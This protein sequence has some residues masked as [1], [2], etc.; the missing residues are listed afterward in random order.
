MYWI[1]NILFLE[2]TKNQ[3]SSLLSF[4]KIFVK[5]HIEKSPEEIL[6]LFI[7]DET[8]YNNQ[9][10]P[11]FEWIIEEF[12]KDKF[13]SELK[14]YISECKKVLEEKNKQ[15]LQTAKLKEEL[16]QQ[17]RKTQETAMAKQKPTKKQLYYYEKLCSRYNIEK[18]DIKGLSRLD[19]KNMIGKIL[20]AQSAPKVI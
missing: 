11:H 14:V 5:K 19:L 15:K 8:Y 10:N 18:V 2:L 4:L 3:K 13:I 9:N 17:K 12:E 6:G 7:E 20:D 16:K 1:K